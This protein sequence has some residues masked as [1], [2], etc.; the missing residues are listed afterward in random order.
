MTYAN[1]PLCSDIVAYMD[2]GNRSDITIT[3]Q[4]SDVDNEVIDPYKVFGLL[5]PLSS[6]SNNCSDYLIIFDSNR[7]NNLSA[8]I[9]HHNQIISDS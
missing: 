5:T 9:V 1:S 7:D 3:S 8:T 4:T 6:S 2:G